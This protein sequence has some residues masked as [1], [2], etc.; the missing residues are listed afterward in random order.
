MSSNS[1]T[2]VEQRMQ[3]K[4]SDLDNNGA[5]WQ[6]P[7][8]RKMAPSSP[9][10]LSQSKPNSTIERV[11]RFAP[12]SIETTEETSNEE[13]SRQ[14]NNPILPN[15]PKIPPIFVYQVHDFSEM[16]KAISTVITKNDY[17]CKAMAN[18]IVKINPTT[19][20]AYRKLA[21]HFRE[22]NIIHH[23]YQLKEDRAFRVVI[24]HLHHSINPEDLKA[25]LADKGFDVK[26]ISNIKHR[27]T[28]KP[29]PLFFID[30]EPNDDNKLIYNIN[31]LLNSKIKIEPPRK[32]N[33]I[34]QC[35]RCQS[36]NHTKAYCCK[37]Y[38]CVRCGESHQSSTCTKPRSTP[39]TC[40]NCKGNHPANYKGCSTYKE[41]QKIKGKTIPRIQPHLIENSTSQSTNT[42]ILP[43]PPLISPPP[44]PPP[45]QK[46][47]PRIPK[48]F[49]DSINNNNNLNSQQND[50]NI[51]LTTL[52]NEFKSMFNQ[53][54]T[55]NSMILSLLSKV[56][57]ENKN[58]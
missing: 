14:S 5:P 11:N 57:T 42:N 12:L 36:F 20:E 28:K 30:L 38:Q 51:Q 21:K 33:V 10:L 27:V 40:A 50:I 13:N 52:L 23:T 39:A 7:K 18:S 41:L 29:L 32:N 37:P 49:A 45:Q 19:S 6:Y 3:Y 55:Q 9:I 15:I 2:N 44:P 43:P 24:R 4:E 8:K 56:M 25:E 1:Q 53:L 46:T 17:I 31:Y 48:T 34:P 26:N 35:A 16:I 54:I 22:N 47:L 58:V